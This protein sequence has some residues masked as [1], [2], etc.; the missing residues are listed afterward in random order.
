MKESLITKLYEATD[1]GLEIIL[2]YYPQAKDCVSGQNKLF[3]I[4]AEERTPSASIK[5]FDDVWRVTD[6]GDDGTAHN[7]IEICMREERLEFREALHR[8]CDRYN[9][10]ATIIS[11]SNKPEIESRSAADGNDFDPF[12]LEIID[13]CD[14]FVAVN[15]ERNFPYC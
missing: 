4:R 7:P 1:K 5:L 13:R 15:E 8:L 14:K 11:Q 2:Y 6:F 10:S 12:A 9:V 3:K